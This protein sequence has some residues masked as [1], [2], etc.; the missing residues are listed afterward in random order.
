MRTHKTLLILF[1]DH[2]ASLRV[3]TTL[4]LNMISNLMLIYTHQIQYYSAPTQIMSTEWFTYKLINT[5]YNLSCV[6]TCVCMHVC[7]YVYVC[8]G[9][10]TLNIQLLSISVNWIVTVM[11]N[12]GWR[13]WLPVDEGRKHAF[14][15]KPTK[16]VS[17]DMTCVHVIEERNIIGL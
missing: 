7:I 11:Q 8:N 12:R 4:K 2:E 3:F 15:L 6:S 5:M 1:C 14:M 10:N 16:I 9:E 17:W 13:K